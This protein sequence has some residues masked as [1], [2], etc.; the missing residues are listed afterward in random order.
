MPS[1]AELAAIALLLQT[2]APEEPQGAGPR[3][4]SQPTTGEQRFDA[5]GYADIGE[6]AG[7]TVSAPG[8]PGGFAEVTSVDT[9]KTIVAI[10]EAGAPPPGRI[11]LLSRGAAQ[12]L[13]L[14]GSLGGI[15]V[16]PINPPGPEIAGLRAGQANV[17]ADAPPALIAALKR[18]LG[19]VPV[20]APAATVRP[21]TRRRPPPLPAAAKQAIPAPAPVAV[22]VAATAPAMLTPG[23]YVQ[24]AALSSQQRAAV[25]AQTVNGVVEQTDAVY[26]V[27]RGPFASDTEAKRERT[28][29]VGLGYRDAQIVRIIP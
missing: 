20:V 10:V 27:H 3:G 5:I 13:G 17:R 26:R 23:F 12:A 18:K 29:A 19:P 15:R 7:I 25:L 28:R 14:T 21:V 6:G 22:P 8:L 4:S 1:L 16:R 24:Y 9:G 11:A 2:G